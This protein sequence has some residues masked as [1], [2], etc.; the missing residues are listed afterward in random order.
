MVTGSTHAS[1]C[2]THPINATVAD[3][4]AQNSM[5]TITLTKIPQVNLKFP[6]FYL[7]FPEFKNSRSFPSF[8]EL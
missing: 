3:N 1:H 8:P 5:P 2:A 7:S 4:Y 6:D